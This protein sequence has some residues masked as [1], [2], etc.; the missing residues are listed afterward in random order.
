MMILSNMVKKW[1]IFCGYF[2]I[3]SERI[4]HILLRGIVSDYKTIE[5]YLAW[6]IPCAFEQRDSIG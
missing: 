4:P 2:D 3:D 1:R 6:K 5:I